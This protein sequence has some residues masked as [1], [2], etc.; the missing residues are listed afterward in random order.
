MGFGQ[1]GIQAPP[2]N[3]TARSAVYGKCRTTGNMPCT[4]SVLLFND[5]ASTAL[6]TINS[7][8]FIPTPSGL[9]TEPYIYSLSLS[10]YT[11]EG[12]LHAAIVFTNSSLT[13]S[14]PLLINAYTSNNTYY[15]TFA[16]TSSGITTSQS[17]GSYYTINSGT[18]TVQIFNLNSNG[19]AD[20]SSPISNAQSYTFGIASPSGSATSQSITQN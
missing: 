2:T 16:P 3:Y 12:F 17:N 5:S 6:P 10:N 15:S 7:F 13:Y 8:S 1:Q 4:A 14:F 19:G 9:Y 20:L 11:S 18:Y